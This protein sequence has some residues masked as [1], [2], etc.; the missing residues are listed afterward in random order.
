VLDCVRTKG[1]GRIYQTP[2]PMELVVWGGESEL[3]LASPVDL[4]VADRAQ[5]LLDASAFQSLWVC[6][7]HPNGD[8]VW[9]KLGR[10]KLGTPR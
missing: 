6:T 1:R 7:A 9:L 5:Q 4:T 8:A 2:H 3:E 10:T